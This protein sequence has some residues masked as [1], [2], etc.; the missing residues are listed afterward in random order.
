MAAVSFSTPDAHYPP[1]MKSYASKA[2]HMQSHSPRPGLGVANMSPSESQWGSCDNESSTGQ[3]LPS[4]S[5]VFPDMPS[6]SAKGDLYSIQPLP[7][8]ISHLQD[9][10]ACSD[11]PETP[12]ET[13]RLGYLSASDHRPTSLMERPDHVLRH[14]PF[15]PGKQSDH[16]SNNG[17][18]SRTQSPLDSVPYQPVR[19]LPGQQTPSL[20]QVPARGCVPTHAGALYDNGASNLLWSETGQEVLD[21]VKAC[22]RTTFHFSQHWLHAQEQ[23]QQ[24]HGS[25]P[26]PK[27]LPTKDDMDDMLF[28]VERLKHCFEQYR[29]TVV[30]CPPN[31]MTR[32]DAKP[33]KGSYKENQ[34][35]IR[36]VDSVKPSHSATEVKKRRGRAAPP[37]S[38]QS[39]NRI[40]T[41]EWRRGPD[42]ART[43]CNACGLQYAKRK[44]QSQKRRIDKNTGS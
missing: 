43:L 34:V 1:N 41:P 27:R 17:V 35:G 33:L 38:C 29:E 28:Q 7:L 40:D 23:Q 3:P 4:I 8:E 24:Q 14:H 11:P 32:E 37:S 5:E 10:T 22:S 12:L 13:G 36:H 16:C 30:S 21:R 44:R 25:Q 9:Q 18:Y 39:C 20:D 19:L 6:F 31:K 26:I 42:G 2:M 15:R